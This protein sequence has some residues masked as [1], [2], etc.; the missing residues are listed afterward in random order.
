MK[1]DRMD[2]NYLGFVNVDSLIEYAETMVNAPRVKNSYQKHK[3]D[4]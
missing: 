4:L 3:Q 2:N 1:T